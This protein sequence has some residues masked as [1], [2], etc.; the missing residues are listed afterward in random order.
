MQVRGLEDEAMN[1][2]NGRKPSFESENLGGLSV[3]VCRL[4]S[5]E[6]WNP[7]GVPLS[8]VRV[9][10]LMNERVIELIFSLKAISIG[11]YVQVAHFSAGLETPRVHTCMGWKGKWYMETLGTVH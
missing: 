7:W 1:R 6:A 3:S 8:F 2:E 10:Y 5:R 11:L 4:L 9:H